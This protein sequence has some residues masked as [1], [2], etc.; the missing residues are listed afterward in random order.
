[1]NRKGDCWHKEAEKAMEVDVLH[2]FNFSATQ[3]RDTDEKEKHARPLE[4]AI[5]ALI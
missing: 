2:N 1:M 4:T 3:I 5:E